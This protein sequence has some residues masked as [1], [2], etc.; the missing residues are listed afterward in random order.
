M[1]QLVLLTGA[2]G[3]YG[4]RIADALRHH[5]FDVATPGRPEFELL[6]GASVERRFAA[7]RPALVMHSAAYYGGL[8]ICVAEPAQI[9]H[10]NVLMAVNL[11]NA[12]ARHHVQRFMAIG[13][14]CAYAGNIAG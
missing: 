7:L 6:D 11:L 1:S 5:G 12:A 3:F 10:R 13:S 8:G 2:R 4:R 14:A 9:F